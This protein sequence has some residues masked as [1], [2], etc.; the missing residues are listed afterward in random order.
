M[1]DPV[2]SVVV[3]SDYAGGTAG[4]LDDFGHCLRA[5]A[6]QDFDEPVEFLL[7]EWVGYRDRIPADLETLLP[8]L[9][10][11]YSDARSAFDLKN[12]G[13]REAR[14]PLVAVLDADCDPA[15]GWLRSAVDTLRSHPEVAAVSGRNLS[16][17]R[18][19]LA[20]IVSLAGRAVGDEGAA[21]PTVHV[22]LNNIAYRRDV[23]LEHPYSSAAGSCGFALHSQGL[24]RA[25]RK[26]LVRSRDGGRPRR[27]GLRDDARRPAP[28]GMTLVLTRK[29]DPQHP[30]AWLV[31]LGYASIPIFVG[32]QDAPHGAAGR[33]AAGGPGGALVRGPRGDRRRLRPSPIRG[34]RHD[35][36]RS[37]ASR[38]GPRISAEAGGPATS[39]GVGPRVSVVIPVYNGANFLGDAI[40]SALAQ[41]WRDVEVIVVDDGSNDDGATADV[42][43]SYGDRIRYLRTDHGGVSSALN[44]GIRAMTG[45]YF[46]WLSHD[47]VYHPA[48]L[49][50]PDRHAGATRRRAI[51]YSDYELVGPDLKR[52]KRKVQPDVPPAG[53]PA[54]AH[55]HFG[56][57][58]LHRPGA[59]DP[60][61]SPSSST[62][63]WRPRRTTTCGSGWHGAI[64]SCACPRSCSGTGSTG[65]RRAG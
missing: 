23:L 16:P 38:S 49:E 31:R 54:V 33:R 10:I 20:R 14:A 44:A 65:D 1:S 12:V 32:R 37:V 13:A 40:D 9:R 8:S 4:S 61:S 21:G 27:H 24:L 26:A 56:A 25:G 48:K 2:F 17:A 50:T 6:A 59:A 29:V 63:G 53:V 35:H 55:G 41:T 5:L 43:R 15:P 28:L 11:V 39:A 34:P 62:S 18:T 22:S 42:A 60:A 7:S 58:R 57:S 51:A 46:A 30:H 47:D 64:A 45:E 19:R 36:W 52:I 3:V